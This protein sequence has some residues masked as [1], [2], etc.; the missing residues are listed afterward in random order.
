MSKIDCPECGGSGGLF[1]SRCER[2]DGSGKV[3]APEQVAV[4]PKL[5]TRWSSSECW[6]VVARLEDVRKALV[7]AVECGRVAKFESTT[8]EQGRVTIRAIVPAY[9]EHISLTVGFEPI[10]EAK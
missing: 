2:C 1:I 3:D 5:Y 9:V 6:P 4:V 8:D 7:A 10:D